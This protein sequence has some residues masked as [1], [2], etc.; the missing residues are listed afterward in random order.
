MDTVHDDRR[1]SRAAISAAGLV[2]SRAPARD[3]AR[4]RAR[5]P[6]RPRPRRPQAP[7]RAFANGLARGR[8]R[9]AR[10][11]P[12]VRADARSSSSTSGSSSRRAVSWTYWN[13][14]FTVSGWRCSGS[15]SAATSAFTRFR[16]T[17]L[18]ANVLGLVRLR[19]HADRAAAAARR[20]ASSTRTR[21]GLVQLA[22]NPY[23]AMPSLHAADS[24][25]VGVVLALVCRRWWAKALLGGLAG[26]GLVRGD[27][28][29]QPLLARLRRRPRGRAASRWRSS[30]GRRRA[31]VLAA[32]RA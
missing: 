25:I 21:D 30:T 3:L 1:C 7:T 5:L 14:E 31:A 29:R 10:H 28:D 12:A 26:L 22:A 9:D 2:G 11:A 32:H 15:T 18:L 16:N 8:L 23:A 24:L 6:D 13:S 17:I 4:L 19:L 20:S 27:G